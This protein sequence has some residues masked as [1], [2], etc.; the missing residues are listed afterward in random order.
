MF[1]TMVEI[2]AMQLYFFIPSQFQIHKDHPRSS[3][4]HT[5]SW[6]FLGILIISNNAV[7]CV[8][9]PLP[10]CLLPIPKSAWGPCCRP[11]CPFLR[12]MT[13]LPKRHGSRAGMETPFTARW[14]WRELE[15]SSGHVSHLKTL[16]F[17]WNIETHDGL[18]WWFLFQICPTSSHG[19]SEIALSSPVNLAFGLQTRTVDWWPCVRHNG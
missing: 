3:S 7:L 5:I 4:E 15:A 13:W 19:S 16:G 1:P 14:L 8:T 17:F 9:L 6:C 10:S 18:E 2:M 11:I 12:P